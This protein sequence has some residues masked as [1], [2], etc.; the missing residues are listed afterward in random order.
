MHRL[1]SVTLDLVFTG[2]PASVYVKVKQ[3]PVC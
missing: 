1:P 2:H 3:N